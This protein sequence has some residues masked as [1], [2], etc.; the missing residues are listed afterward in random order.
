MSGVC[1]ER[2]VDMLIALLAILKAGGAYVPLDPHFPKA[3]LDLILEDARPLL[4]LTESRLAHLVSTPETRILALD[5][6]RA[7]YASWRWE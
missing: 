7:T 4:V 1:I 5:T 3:R 6:E 2:S